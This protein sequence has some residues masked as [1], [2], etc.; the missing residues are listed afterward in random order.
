MIKVIRM[1]L[2]CGKIGDQDRNFDYAGDGIW[3]CVCGSYYTEITET[4][5]S[6]G[7]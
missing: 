2:K 4:I 7:K 6:E 5:E 3:H 1:C